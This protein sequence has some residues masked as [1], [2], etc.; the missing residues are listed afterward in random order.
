MTLKI[1]AEL[2]EII[3]ADARAK[4][5]E[6]CCGTLLGS[7]ASD[8]D[9]R[10]R[11]VIP[12]ANAQG[13]QRERRYLISAGRVRDI[14]I[15]AARSGLEVVGYYHSH[16]DHPGEPSEVD[17]EAAWPWYSYVIVPVRNGTPGTPRSWRLADDRSRFQEERIDGEE[18]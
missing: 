8:V 17:R 11:R 14:D 5:P 13:E 9:R 18:T 12:V 15:E 2:M 1:S 4:Y 16:P 10:V 3:E 7:P 6:E